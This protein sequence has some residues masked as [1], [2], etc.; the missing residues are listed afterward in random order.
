[1][2]VSIGTE[3]YLALAKGPL[4]TAESS[5][6][7]FPGHIIIITIAH[8][9]ISSSTEAAEMDDYQSRLTKFFSEKGCHAVTWEI[10][11]NE[12]VHAHRQVVAVPQSKLLEDAFIEGFSEKKM[13]LEKR[14][15]GESEEYCRVVLPSG[16]F[17]A[18]LPPRFDLQ[19]PRRIL[20]KVLDVEE[21]MDWR[22]CIQDEEEEKAD[23]LTFRNTFETAGV[24][25]QQQSA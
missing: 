3:V 5:G 25:Q 11:H 19:L 20:A 22:S 7:P 8:T 24:T 10:R 12:G 17:V 6:L 18:T 16:S 13:V 1:M 2:I 21:R 23:G 4:T 15:P 14:E 9:P